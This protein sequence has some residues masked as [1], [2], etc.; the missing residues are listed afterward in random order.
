MGQAGLSCE[1]VALSATLP[2]CAC[3]R[4]TH[5]P[6]CPQPTDDLPACPIPPCLVHCFTS[7]R[8]CDKVALFLLDDFDGFAGKR[9][10]QT[11]LYNLLDALQTSGMQ[12]GGW[13]WDGM[14][15]LGKKW[16]AVWLHYLSQRRLLP[17][18]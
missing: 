7:S 2:C 12:V 1:R 4:L 15:C 14:G 3:V 16:R 18:P 10:K 6:S 8:S 13:A 17:G 9:A 5:S 11:V